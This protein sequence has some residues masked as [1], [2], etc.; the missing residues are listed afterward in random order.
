MKKLFLLISS[1]FALYGAQ[2]QV[3]LDEG[4]LL[5]LPFNGNADDASG[6]GND[7]T[8]YGATLTADAAGTPNSAYYFDGTND[9][10][11]IPV[12]PMLA[13]MTD[14]LTFAVKV[15]PQGF[16]EGTCHGNCIIDIG[17]N[18][19]YPNAYSLRYSANFYLGHDCETYDTVHQNY[20]HQYAGTS[21]EIADAISSEP[22][23]ESGKWDC[24]IYTFDGSMHRMYVNGDLRYELE[25]TVSE[26]G[27]ITGNIFLGKKNDTGYPYWMNATL[28]EVR[29]YNRALNEEEINAYCKGGQVSI[30]QVKAG[31]LPMLQ[32]PVDDVLRLGI[33]DTD[34]HGSLRVTDLSGRTMIHIAQLPSAVVPVDGL[35]AGMYLV[36]YHVKGKYLR[37]K[38]VKR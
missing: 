2:A 14:S 36:D 23:I 16:Y 20:S 25:N 33:D 15:K 12:V 38:I 35:A 17:V 11:K 29:I 34:L 5:Y 22:Y 6:N 1:V 32:N 27:A 13:A 21:T 9:Y 10:M 28:D 19:G 24:V 31:K 4:L 3:A 7:A 18:D 30:G 37:T 8:N 26:P